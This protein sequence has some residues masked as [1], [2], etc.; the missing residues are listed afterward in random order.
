MSGPTYES[1]RV[2]T[3]FKEFRG[4]YES[5]KAEALTTHLRD[6]ANIV[7]VASHVRPCSTCGDAS[8]LLSLQEW[9]TLAGTREGGWLTELDTVRLP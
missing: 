7:S 1:Q 4:V 8:R 6:V 3:Q 5:R 9:E 2:Y